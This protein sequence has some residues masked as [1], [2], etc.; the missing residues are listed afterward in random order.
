[1]PELTA[2]VLGLQG[3]LEEHIS[4]LED[5]MSSLDIRGNVIVV[6]EVENVKKIDA[7]FIPGGESTVIGSLAAIRGLLPAIRERVNMGLPALGTC[8]GMIIL[9]KKAYDRVIGETNQSLLGVMDITVERNSFGR[10]RESFEATVNL[11][12]PGGENYTAVFIR[13]PVIKSIGQGVTKLGEYEG[14]VVAAKQ[15]NIVVTSFHPELSGNT[16]VH[17]FVLRLALS[18]K[19]K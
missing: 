17:E 19:S 7:I 4:A 1:M 16:A 14:N 10:Q 13:A 12:I 11:N 18:R 15:G 8:A 3:D 6:K 5:S 9:A 2:G